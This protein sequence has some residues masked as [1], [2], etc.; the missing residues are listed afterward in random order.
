[1]HVLFCFINE[2]ALG[3]INRCEDDLPV[4]FDHLEEIMQLC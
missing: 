3:K 1:M 2:Q 4:W